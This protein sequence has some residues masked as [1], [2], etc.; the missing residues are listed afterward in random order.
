ME[1]EL[2]LISVIMPA[3]N[4]GTF[5]P[6]AIE[7]VLAQTY[8]HFELIIIDDGSTDHTPDICRAYAKKD[9]R[10]HVFR[11]QNQGPAAARNAGI[12]L[13]KGQFIC[14]L[15]ADDCMDPKKIEI[16]L[17]VMQQNP[18]IDITYTALKL[19][20]DKGN[21]LGE[22][23]SQDYPPEVLVAQMF[24]RNVISNA[25]TI[26]AKRFCLERNAYDENYKYA[27]DYDLMM[28]LVHQYC[29]KY[30]DIP[31]TL[32]R[33]HGN[34]LSDN[35]KAHRNT[36]TKVINRYSK[37]HVEEIIEKSGLSEEEKL[38]MKGK[39]F[40]NM[41]KF[42]DALKSL[43]TLSTP[44]ALFYRGNCYLKFNQLDQAADCYLNA[45][46]H[47]ASNPACH[48]NLGAVYWMQG[49]Q[50]KAKQAFHHALELKPGYLDAK[51]N[52]ENEE[53]NKVPHITWRELRPTIIPY[54]TKK[55]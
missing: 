16:Q 8:H 27:E 4:P 26:M 19:I 20:D 24:F 39:I 35:L 44:L 45:L 9:A 5:L 22:I 21:T 32:Y 15:D 25:N 14:L 17:S 37:E 33:R 47:D 10:I 48:N 11:Q 7:S 31:L 34:N 53:S 12:K 13:S 29:F 38:F 52:L 50:E 42:Q 28:R 18:E 41:E 2:P 3:Y 23:H 55:D 1:K 51:A 49:R 6:T 36:E 43:E 54:Q 46:K 30:V 40:F